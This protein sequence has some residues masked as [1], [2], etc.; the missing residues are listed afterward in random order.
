MLPTQFRS[1]Y[2]NVCLVCISIFVYKSLFHIKP[3][4]LFDSISL[5]FFSRSFCVC[6]LFFSFVLRLM[7]LFY[8]CLDLFLALFLFFFSIFIIRSISS[9]YVYIYSCIIK[10]LDKFEFDYEKNCTG[11]VIL[12]SLFMFEFVFVVVIIIIRCE[13]EFALFRVSLCLLFCPFFF[14]IFSSALD[15]PFSC[16]SSLIRPF[17]HRTKPSRFS[18]FRFYFY[19]LLPPIF[20]FN[21]F[22]FSNEFFYF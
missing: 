9:I 17:F 16:L 8:F 6:E 2:M 13:C 3:S 22:K 18:S 10:V 1:T 4:A 20:S 11:W 19:F 5:P 21:C 14:F 15:W 7:L 12:L